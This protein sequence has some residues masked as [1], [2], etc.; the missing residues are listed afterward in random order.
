MKFAWLLIDDE[1]EDRDKGD[2]KAIIT[3]IFQLIC[4]ENIEDKFESEE[5]RKKRRNERQ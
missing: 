4:P 3:K 5:C 2:G 1:E